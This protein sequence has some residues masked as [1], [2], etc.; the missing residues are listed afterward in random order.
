MRI[1]SQDDVH[2]TGYA[3]QCRITTE[4]PE[5]NFQ[6]DYGTLIAYRSAAGFGIRLD[7]GA[8][9]TGAEYRRFLIRCW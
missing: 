8:A 3:V 6:P 9:Y 4:D 1:A 5:N 7:V 2:C